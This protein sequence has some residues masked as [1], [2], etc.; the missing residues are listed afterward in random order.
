M[1]GSDG[2]AQGA[3]QEGPTLIIDT[4]YGMTIGLEGGEPVVEEESRRHVELLEPTLDRVM[5]QAGLK[6]ND[7]RAIIV[8]VGPAPFTGLRTG[9]V[10]AK[11]LS[12]ATGARLL[13][14]DIL[15]AQAAW[16]YNGRDQVGLVESAVRRLTLAV[17]DAR[18]RQLYFA[19]Y[20]Q[21]DPGSG[22]P[23]KPL[24]SMDID[25][26][27]RIVERVNQVCADLLVQEPGRAVQVDVAGRGL[28]RYE[29]SWQA[30]DY[31][32][33]VA[34]DVIFEGGAEGL[35]V[36]AR[37]ALRQREPR[38]VEPLYLRRPDVS[39]PKPLKR[40]MGA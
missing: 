13:G 2:K 10:A 30:L 12:F 23:G 32:G 31:V 20:D 25:H 35:R 24:I 9:I 26:P 8:G 38:P 21:P 1:S 15:S 5:R 29:S 37:C 36:F 18:R 3:G 6:A 19:L 11:A 7:L 39:V 16:T 14:Q 33:R 22:A 17:N 27:D 28:D 34:Q 4:S 40:V